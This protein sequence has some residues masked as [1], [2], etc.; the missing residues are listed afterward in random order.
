MGEV[1]P[2]LIAVVPG[3][4]ECAGMHKTNPRVQA[5][6]VGDAPVKELV[7]SLG[8]P[9]ILADPTSISSYP[10]PIVIWELVW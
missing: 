7:R 2:L 6:P 10:L 3:G 9:L 1:A 5:V 4:Q 8:Q